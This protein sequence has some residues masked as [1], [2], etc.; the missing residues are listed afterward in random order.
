MP[1]AK[2]NSHTKSMSMTF[3]AILEELVHR[4]SIEPKGLADA[5][6]HRI[7]GPRSRETLF[8]KCMMVEAVASPR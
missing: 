3:G 4:R 2:Q 8:A 1:K 6:A 7:A 5:V